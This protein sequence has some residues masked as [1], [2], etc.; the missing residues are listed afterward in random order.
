MGLAASIIMMVPFFSPC[1]CLGS[2]FGIWSVV[3][4]NDAQV[5]DAFQ[6]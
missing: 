4:L 5:K 3:V 2:P 1:C 6:S